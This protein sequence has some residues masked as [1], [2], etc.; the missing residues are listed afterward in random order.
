MQTVV[1]GEPLEGAWVEEEFSQIKSWHEQQSQ[2]SCCE[3]DE[4]F[5]EQ[6]RQNVIGRL[7]LQQ[8]AEKLDWEPAQEAVTEAIASSPGL[9]GEEAFRASVGMG[10]GQALLRAQM[11]G[12]LKLDQLLNLSYQDIED[13]AEETLRSFHQDHARAYTKEGRVRALH[14]FKSM[15]Q[16]EDREGLFKECCRV[17]DRLVQGEDFTEVAQS[18]SDK[19]AEEIAWVFSSVAI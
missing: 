7:L 14:I 13:P 11:V 9:Q 3:R 19:P 2:V 8:A 1:N 12:N 18:F 16:A 6:A 5:R 17:R 4:E 15:R 10:E